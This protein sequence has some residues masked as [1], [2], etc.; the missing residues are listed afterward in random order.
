[1]NR[2]Q[3]QL[4]VILAAITAGSVVTFEYLRWSHSRLKTQPVSLVA[5]TA[6]ET[7][8][9]TIHPEK[10]EE[11]ARQSQFDTSTNQS[12]VKTTVETHTKKPKEISQES[13][14]DI[15]ANPPVAK[16]T[17]QPPGAPCDYNQCK[18]NSQGSQTDIS[19]NR[20]AMI[21]RNKENRTVLEARLIRTRF[22][23]QCSCDSHTKELYFNWPTHARPSTTK[24][25]LSFN[26][27]H[28]PP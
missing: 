27:I 8:Q 16:T 21:P 10:Q 24:R 14:N 4:V 22:H 1:M 26:P 7:A 18:E 20:S 28:G 19:A 15:S 25:T 2:T 23:V 6:A 11:S 13:H 3:T 12:V 5:Q 17:T 9:V